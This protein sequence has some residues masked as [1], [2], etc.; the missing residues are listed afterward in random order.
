MQA[1]RG[2]QEAPLPTMTDTELSDICERA[3]ALL[4]NLPT[5]MAQQAEHAIGR[6]RRLL[7]GEKEGPDTLVIPA[8]DCLALEYEASDA[9][10][11]DRA[12]GISAAGISAAV[13]AWSAS[14]IREAIRAAREHRRA[15][16]REDHEEAAFIAASAD[17]WAGMARK[18][19]AHLHLLRVGPWVAV[20]H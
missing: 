12:A 11:R 5:P 1:N 16:R 19:Q 6:A 8:W 20:A 17:L 3:F 18:P 13:A 7:A 4:P 14:A 10:G 2:W 15:R 9:L